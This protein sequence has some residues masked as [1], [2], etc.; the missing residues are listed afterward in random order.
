M[1][2]CL[3]EADSIRKQRKKPGYVIYF[4][5]LLL[6]YL[7]TPTNYELDRQISPETTQTIW[8]LFSVYNGPIR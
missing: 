2:D 3:S 1:Y 7:Q 5:F 8:P 6:I 4:F